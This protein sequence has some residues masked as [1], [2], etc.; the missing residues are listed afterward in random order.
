[1]GV[2]D[3]QGRQVAELVDEQ[4]PAGQYLRPWMGKGHD[5]RQLAAGVYFLRIDFE[6]II[7][8]RKLVVS[9]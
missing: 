2:Y 7:E 3:V 6:G 9:H 4:Q 5:G 8:S 1:M